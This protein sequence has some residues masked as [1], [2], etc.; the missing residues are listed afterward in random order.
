MAFFFVVVACLDTFLAAESDRKVTPRARKLEK[1]L[2]EKLTE[3]LSTDVRYT[4]RRV[5]AA[6]M[7]NVYLGP[8]RYGKIDF[9][10]R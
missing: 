5:L 3:F 4:V 1:T 9:V 2:A 7:K 10:S 6:E 8:E